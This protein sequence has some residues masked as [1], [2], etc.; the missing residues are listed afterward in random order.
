[1]IEKI[2]SPVCFEIWKMLDYPKDWMFDGMTNNKG[3]SYVIV[4]GTTHISLWICNGRWFLDGRKGEVYLYDNETGRAVEVLFKTKA[5]EIGY[6]DRHIL[7]P[8]VQK[9]VKYLDNQKGSSEPTLVDE[10]RR[11][12]KSREWA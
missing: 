5:P 4:H 6:L 12:N 7:W 10:L 11:Y 2:L 8:K 9:V 3:M 1:M